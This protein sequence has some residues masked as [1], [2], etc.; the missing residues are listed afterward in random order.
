MYVLNDCFAHALLQSVARTSWQVFSNDSSTRRSTGWHFWSERETA[1]H[2]AVCMSLSEKQTFSSGRSRLTGA[3]P[4][5]YPLQL[6]TS[7]SVLRS[8]WHWNYTY[9]PNNL[10]RCR[11]GKIYLRT[12]GSLDVSVL[13]DRPANF[14]AFVWVFQ[15]LSTLWWRLHDEY[16][17]GE[18]SWL[19]TMASE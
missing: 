13:V 19:V 12:V 14:D 16:L 6:L 2:C 7:F 5:H 17:A 18:S 9:R 4:G 3:R 11:R 10:R 1:R 8:A 15:Q